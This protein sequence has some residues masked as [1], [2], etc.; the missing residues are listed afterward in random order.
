MSA[1]ST[2][3]DIGLLILRATIGICMLTLHGLPKLMGGP[4]MWNKVGLAMGNLGINFFPI[5]W[6]FSAAIVESLCSLFIVIGLWTRQ[7]SILLAFTML[8]ATITHLSQG[9][10]FNT[11]SHA[12]EL[13][14]VFIA[15]S[16]IGP[17]K[18]SVDKR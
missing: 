2:K 16:L 7:N 10:G 8:T 13:M 1:T 15:L 6:G 14:S 12:I 9:D 17:G 5:A 4:D 11:A 3:K 18:Y